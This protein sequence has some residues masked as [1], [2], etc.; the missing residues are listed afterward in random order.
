MIKMSDLSAGYGHEVKIQHVNCSFK[1]QEITVIVGMNGCGKSTLLKTIAGLIKPMNGTIFLQVNSDKKEYINIAELSDKEHARQISYLPQNRNVP[2]ISVERM[3]LHGRFPYLEYP[4]RYRG[5][6]YKIAEDSLKRVEMLA[7]K[8][9]KMTQ[10][11]GGERQK[12][13]I[14]MALA[15]DTPVILLDEPSSFLD[16]TYQLE[17]LDLMKELKKEGKMVITVMHDIDAALQLADHMIVMDKGEVQFAGSPD[18]V[19]K[20]N[21]IEKVF[22]V[23]VKEQKDENRNSHY[24]FKKNKL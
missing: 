21:V 1:E 13:Y 12:I 6:D 9:K 20:E 23:T 16:L 2:S 15:Q 8:E 18:D 4:R 5:E 14:A 7:I 3:V 24:F 17:I 11:S 19:C 22:G 10:L